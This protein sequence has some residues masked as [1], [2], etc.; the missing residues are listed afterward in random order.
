MTPAGQKSFENAPTLEEV[1]KQKEKYKK[2]QVPPHPN[3]ESEKALGYDILL[4]FPNLEK[5]RRHRLFIPKSVL[6]DN[7]NIPF[8]ILEKKVAELDREYANWGGWRIENHPFDINFGSRDWSNLTS[9]DDQIQTHDNRIYSIF[10]GNSCVSED[11]ENFVFCA[12]TKIN[13]KAQDFVED[14]ERLKKQIEYWADKP[15]AL[16]EW[17]ESDHPR[18]DEGKFGN[19]GNNIEK[20]SKRDKIRNRPRKEIQL[21]HDEYA[22]V[23]HELNTNLPKELK[24]KKIFKRTIG[25]YTYKVQNNGF[26][27]YKI[28]GK[29][30]IDDIYN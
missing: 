10:N 29:Q 2:G 4:E 16:D 21:P 22:R 1:E 9:E 5:T 17:N 26:N 12:D 20:S 25:N 27:E 24:N 8:W 14:E 6:M 7:G 30:N 13:V 28:I 23:I 15:K 11:G 18:D 3:W 19:G